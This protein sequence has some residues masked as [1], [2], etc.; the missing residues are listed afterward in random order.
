MPNRLGAES[1]TEEFRRGVT[2]EPASRLKRR[3]QR[4]GSRRKE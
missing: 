4:C 1:H 2:A 3:G